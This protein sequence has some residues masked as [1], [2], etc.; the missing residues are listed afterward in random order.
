MCSR[1]SGIP[2]AIEVIFPYDEPLVYLVTT[3]THAMQIADA[4][5]SNIKLSVIIT[6]IVGILSVHLPTVYFC[7]LVANCS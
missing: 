3:F 6:M 1:V 4:V 2:I 5:K 7:T